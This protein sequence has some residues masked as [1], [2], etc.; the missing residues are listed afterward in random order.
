LNKNNKAQGNQITPIKD[1]KRDEDEMC[2]ATESQSKILAGQQK[3]KY[4]INK[5]VMKKV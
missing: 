3:N 2:D 5:R 1:E 4:F